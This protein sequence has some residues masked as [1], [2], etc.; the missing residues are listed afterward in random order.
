[1][2]I[3]VYATLSKEVELADGHYLTVQPT[4]R[5]NRF[6]VKISRTRDARAS[7]RHRHISARRLEVDKRD[8]IRKD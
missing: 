7:V 5:P 3:A 6:F 8:G 2:E 1:M 4:R